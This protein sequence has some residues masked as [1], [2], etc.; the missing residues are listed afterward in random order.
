MAAIN[1][2]T[3]GVSEMIITTWVGCPKR[4]SKWCVIT[5]TP[6][7]LSDDMRCDHCGTTRTTQDDVRQ[8]AN[9]MVSYNLNQMID[10][11]ECDR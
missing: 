5:C 10:I 1:S 11:S 3:F 4:P 2:I 6:L 8:V 9:R 7:T